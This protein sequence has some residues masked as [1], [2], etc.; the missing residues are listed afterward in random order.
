MTIVLKVAGLDALVFLARLIY[1]ILGDLDWR[2]ATII[3][4]Y[5]RGED[6]TP[7]HRLIRRCRMRLDRLSSGLN[8]LYGK[9][10]VVMTQH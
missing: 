7:A 4:W 2:N 3:S 8:G 6:G 9:I 1:G 10:R 5:I